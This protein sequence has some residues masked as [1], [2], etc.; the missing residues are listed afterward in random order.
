MK[1]QNPMPGTGTGDPYIFLCSSCE[2]YMVRRDPFLNKMAAFQAD[3]EGTEGREDIGISAGFHQNDT[4]TN[5]LDRK[6]SCT[7]AIIL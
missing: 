2:G 7:K 5:L 3:G 4:I 6:E 1:I